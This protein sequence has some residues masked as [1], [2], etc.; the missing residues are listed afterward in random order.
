M[1][2]TDLPLYYNAVEILEHNLPQR[3]SKTALYSLERRLSFQEISDEANRVG[4]ALKR[5]DVRMGDTVALLCLD[6]A[7]W[8]TSFFGTLKVGAVSV[9]LNT[10]LTS[11]EY[12]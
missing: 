2:A 1:R 10:L 12:D 7:E 5:L 3:A 8:V 11:A 4:N 9:G 6:V